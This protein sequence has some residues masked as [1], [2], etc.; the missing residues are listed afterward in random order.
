[1]PVLAFAGGHPR[2]CPDA[3]TRS[4]LGLSATAYYQRLLALL[5]RVEAAVVEP[6][7]VER[8]RAE[9]NRRRQARW[10]RRLTRSGSAEHGER[11]SPVPSNRSTTGPA[12]PRRPP[13]DVGR[14]VS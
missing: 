14:P 1:L 2:R 7:L 12:P 3:L 9:R 13:P 4:A 5:D 11:V 10:R 6:A 8:L